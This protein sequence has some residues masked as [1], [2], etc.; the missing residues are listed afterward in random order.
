MLTALVLVVA[1]GCARRPAHHEVV[2]WAWQRTEDLS[3][4][5]PDVGV[6]FL[7]QTLFVEDG[8]VSRQPRNAPLHVAPGKPL[9]AVTRI[10]TRGLRTDAERAPLVDAVVATA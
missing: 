5:P 3:R 6:A 4:L 2:L 7:T 9:T 10:E 1:A 8:H